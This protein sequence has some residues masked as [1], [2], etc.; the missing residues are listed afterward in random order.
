M[1]ATETWGEEVQDL[2]FKITSPTLFGDGRINDVATY[3]EKGE[4]RAGVEMLAKCSKVV[5]E[6]Q[7]YLPS[8]T[9]RTEHHEQGKYIWDAIFVNYFVDIIIDK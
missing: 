1:T 8:K 7:E 3:W 6:G 5:F 9:V 4:E 2:L